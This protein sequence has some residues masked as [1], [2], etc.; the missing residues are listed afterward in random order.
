MGMAPGFQ[1]VARV[2]ALLL[3]ATVG[4]GAPSSLDLCLADCAAAQRCQVLG[5]EGFDSCQKGCQ[6]QAEML[7]ARDQSEEDQCSNAA[8]IRSR[9]MECLQS[10]CADITPCGAAIDRRC[11]PR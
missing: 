1:I 11:R 7:A 4:C 3:G 2:G 8:E 9:S 6:A 5:S 10:D